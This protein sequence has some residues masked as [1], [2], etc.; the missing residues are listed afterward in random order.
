MTRLVLFSLVVLLSIQAQAQFEP[1]SF[2]LNG[3]WSNLE[4]D[5][6]NEDNPEHRWNTN[7]AKFT[8]GYFPAKNFLLAVQPEYTRLLFVDETF[9]P[10]LSNLPFNFTERV[11]SLAA[12]YR[13]Y[14]K[15]GRKERFNLSFGWKGQ[16]VWYSN[17]S[18][19]PTEFEE[20]ISE[21]LTLLNVEFGINTKLG[22]DLFW[23]IYS[24]HP[25][26][27][28]H[29]ISD[30]N[31][32]F[33]YPLIQQYKG[34]RIESK[35]NLILRPNNPATKYGPL[36]QKGEKTIAG[37]GQFKLDSSFYRI[38]FSFGWIP[39]NKTLLSFNF[40]FFS[41][42]EDGEK[43]RQ[44]GF[45]FDYRRY[46][47]AYHRIGFFLGVG[48]SVLTNGTDD[49]ERRGISQVEFIPSGGFNFFL[50]KNLALEWKIQRHFEE[51]LI[52]SATQTYNA[53]ELY[54]RRIT[55]GLRYFIKK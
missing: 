2:H 3:N 20:K 38:N 50:Q 17:K 32:Y 10:N 23:E 14:I 16:K 44:Y 1:G 28:S 49:E 45:G 48:A 53:N 39:E 42:F 51:V 11:F 7:Q 41:S 40:P 54:Q 22:D 43:F 24:S 35:L 4:A 9:S 6:N 8:I 34:W 46:L 33:E 13:Y 19:I 12:F 18:E 25:I 5:W 37:S 52:G 15:M 36:F 47:F 30:E 27:S 29:E 21:K 31:F 55:L 26:V